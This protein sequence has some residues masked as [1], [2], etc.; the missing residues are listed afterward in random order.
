MLNTTS[1]RLVSHDVLT[2]QVEMSDNSDTNSN[3]NQ[4]TSDNCIYL[5]NGIF[6][7]QQQEN[8]ILGSGSYGNV[9]MGKHHLPSRDEIVAI[10]LHDDAFLLQREVKIYHYLWKYKKKGVVPDL[11]IPRLLWNG[12]CD[13]HPY[14]SMVMERLGISLDKLFDSSNKTWTPETVCWVA[15][16]AIQLLRELHKLGIIHR[17]IKPDN[18]ALGHSGATHMKLYIFDFGLSSQ[19]INKEGQHNPVKQGLSLI[20]TMRYA[21]INNHKGV[22]QSR[23]DDLEALFYVLL[24]FHNGTLEWKHVSNTI[25]DRTERN[26]QTMQYK[27]KMNTDTI[28][29]V[30]K[31]FYKHVKQLGYDEKPDYDKWETWF[32]KASKSTSQL[33]DWSYY[34]ANK[35]TQDIFT[36]GNYTIKNKK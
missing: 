34:Y 18:F 26:I 5:H 1:N 33:P 8:Q 4:E 13:T 11:H 14:D 25:D 21:S 22:L 7:L 24:Y 3:T 31:G 29:D 32:S 16:K 27:E 17:D 30:L 36:K 6:S 10:K 2:Q 23:R 35:H 12:R 20:G 9:Y 19:Y 28:P 15:Y